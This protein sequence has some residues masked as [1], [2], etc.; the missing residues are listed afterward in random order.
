MVRVLALMKYGDMAAS[1]RQRLLQYA[2]SFNESDVIVECSPLLDN[3]YIKKSF[4]GKGYS[5]YGLVK[6][7]LRRLMLLVRKQ[8]FDLIWVHCELYPFLPSFFERLVFLKN[9]PVVYDYD[10]AIFHGYDTHPSRFV[11][12]V[13][14]R[15]LQP[16][17]R[18]ASLCLCG[19]NYLYDYASEFCDNS[20]VIPTVVDINAYSP[21]IGG[22][23]PHKT[24]VGWIGSPSTWKYV[25]PVVPLLRRLVSEGRIDVHIV[26]AGPAA[27]T[28]PEFQFFPWS[29]AT[30][31]D[32]IRA[33]DIGLMPLP[34]ENWA[35]GKCGYKLIQYMACGLPTIA[36]PVGVNSEIVNSGV[37]G[38]LA[39]SEEEWAL[40]LEKLIADPEK[41]KR[42][43]LHGR[44]KIVRDYSMQTYAPK[45]L[46][47]LKSLVKP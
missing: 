20:H 29:E 35:R 4:N 6:S 41:R 13:L 28:V 16:L 32:A 7:Y 31:V 47:H 23:G 40:A 37:N 39:T 44:E 9:T 2:E 33:M 11:R 19:N 30:E 8:E 42:F 15:K 46:E 21:A 27:A 17:M 12:A 5:K 10:D 45:I 36:S 14:G 24:V 22:R 43:G 3:E 26:G 34:D 38:Y 25:G 18:G 1:T